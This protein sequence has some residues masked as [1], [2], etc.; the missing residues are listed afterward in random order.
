LRELAERLDVT[1]I[2]FWIAYSGLEPWGPERDEIS[3]ALVGAA[4]IKALN[5]ADVPVENLVPKYEGHD[6]RHSDEE[7]QFLARAR[8]DTWVAGFNARFKGDDEQSR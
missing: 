3:R 1:E 6:D 8:W 7:R 2:P 4:T 5:G